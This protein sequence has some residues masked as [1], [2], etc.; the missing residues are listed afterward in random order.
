[1]PPKKKKSKKAARGRARSG[2]RKADL[3]IVAE[4]DSACIDDQSKQTPESSQNLG[5]EAKSKSRESSRTPSKR[6]RIRTRSTESAGN[7]KEFHSEFTDDD[8]IMVSIN[9]PPG[10]DGDLGGSEDD[11]DEDD[12]V[13]KGAHSP[14]KFSM[15]SDLNSQ[16][17]LDSDSSS[18]SYS[19][20]SRPATLA[21]AV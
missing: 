9:A 7:S 6:N 5:N 15:H 13:V 2:P 3:K 11:N 12:E 18:A 19:S 21:L 1:M 14:E 16:L 20:S 8:G 17:A 4:T 10:K